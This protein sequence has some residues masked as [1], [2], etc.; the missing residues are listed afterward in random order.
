MYLDEYFRTPGNQVARE[1]LL[2]HRLI[3]DLKLETARAG[4][5][6]LCTTPEVD[7]DGRDLVFRL[8]AETRFI[9]CKAYTG[10]PQSNWEIHKR[11][12]TPTANEAS[13]ILPRGRWY[14]HLGFGGALIVISAQPSGDGLAVEYQFADLMTIWA[15]SQKLIR[16]KRTFR[17]RSCASWTNFRK[18]PPGSSCPMASF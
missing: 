7:R 11:V 10:R 14:V 2:S 18:S 12:I 3:Y 17:R 15:L 9:Q 1:Q 8:E 16:K 13:D 5:S 4:H 6:L